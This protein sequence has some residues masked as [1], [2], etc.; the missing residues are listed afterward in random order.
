[1]G[2]IFNYFSLSI[3][4]GNWDQWWGPGIHTSLTMSNNTTGFPYFMIG[5]LKEN[6]IKNLGLNIRYIVSQLKKIQKF[7]KKWGQNFQKSR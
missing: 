2:L 6:K 5:T 3:G 1:M 4:Y 7:K